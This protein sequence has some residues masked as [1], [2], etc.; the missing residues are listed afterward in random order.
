MIFL[1]I[2]N[3]IKMAIAN[4]RNEVFD[5]PDFY[6]TPSWATLALLSKEKFIGSVHEPCCGSGAISTVLIEA[7]LSV[8]S[9]DLYDYGFGVSGIDARELPGPVENII[10]NT[11]YNITE[12]ILSHFLMICER[13]IALLLRLSFLESKRRYP[14]F[15]KTPPARVYVFSERLSLCKVGDTVKGG[16]TISYGWFV[17]EYPHMSNTI[18][19]WIPPGF[20]N[21]RK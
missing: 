16:G 11:P 13:K 7:G 21:R 10:T 18:L 6:P 9:S 12:A 8:I 15:S 4:R 17:W 19:G 2:G 1:P 14:L 5:G 3:L 20:K